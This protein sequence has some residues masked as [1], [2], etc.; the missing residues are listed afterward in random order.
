MFI[1]V[2]QIA[3]KK[4]LVNY[5]N[6]KTK[7]TY[8]VNLIFLGE[9]CLQLDTTEYFLMSQLLFVQYL[10]HNYLTNDSGNM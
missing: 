9:L 2:Y 6:T 5:S 8:R 10:T 1:K 7:N 4:Q 3:K